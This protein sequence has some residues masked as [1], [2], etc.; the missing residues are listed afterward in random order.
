MKVTLETLHL[1]LGLHIF[2]MNM[3]WIHYSVLATEVHT[4]VLLLVC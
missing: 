4:I 1:L 3:G 2:H